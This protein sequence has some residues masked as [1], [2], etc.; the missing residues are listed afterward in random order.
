MFSL[1]ESHA[2]HAMIN[3]EQSR[4]STSFKFLV[5]GND[6][7]QHIERISSHISRLTRVSLSLSIRTSRAAHAC[8]IKT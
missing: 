4:I 2:A 1:R 6:V 7:R 3:M 5:N 8:A